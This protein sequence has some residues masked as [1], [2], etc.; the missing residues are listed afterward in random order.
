MSGISIE[1]DMGFPWAG[2]IGGIAGF[3]TR[4]ARIDVEMDEW[5]MVSLGARKFNCIKKTDKQ[6]FIVADDDVL[7]V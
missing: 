4:L 5:K 7:E 6:V 3:P 1:F 2:G